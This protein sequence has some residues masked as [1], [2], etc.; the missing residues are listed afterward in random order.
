VTSPRVPRPP[1]VGWAH[2]VGQGREKVTVEEVRTR[3][4][5][6]Y[7]RWWDPK[8]ANWTTRSLRRTLA[9]ER[10]RPL[11]GRARKDA[12]TWAIR[13]AEA[14]YNANLAGLPVGTET[15]GTREA[16]T[17][18]A[19][20]TLGAT[21]ARITDPETGI[22][23][24]ATNH[25]RQVVAA[26]RHAVSVLGGDTRWEDLGHA[27][28]R[29]FWRARFDAVRQR[30]R[31][32]DRTRTYDGFRGP[33]KEMNLLVGLRTKLV[34]EG[35]IGAAPAPGVVPLKRAWRADMTA[36]F[37]AL[38]GRGEVPDPQRPRYT[39]AEMLALFVALDAPETDP[40][41]ALAVILAAGQRHGQ[42]VRARRSWL[43]LP[44]YTE[45]ASSYGTLT[46]RGRGKKAGAVVELTAGERRALDRALAADGYLGVLEAAYQAG[47][48]ADYP[49]FP[50][51]KLT[52]WAPSRRASERKPLHAPLA[53]AEAAP[54]HENTMRGW[55]HAL[56]ARA[57]VP[58]VAGRGFYGMR[59]HDLDAI[60]ELGVS[61]TALQEAGGWKTS[62][63]PLDIY[64]LKDN[65]RAR[66]EA[67]DARR[68]VRGE[69]G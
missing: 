66:L 1:R 21:E 43:A 46:I 51:G 10:G 19:P 57:G 36:D 61:L 29:R 54:L 62:K 39:A 52:T 8:R 12:E 28:W 38:H 34:D 11:T 45:D 17:S 30:P 4:G 40:R 15:A 6:L 68:K 55:L 26:L 60:D 65:Q 7:L 2:V 5:V 18:A 13:Q 67:R 14:Q 69:E 3:A 25:R 44:T 22:Y 53:R 9:D 47:T 16:T 50:E 35:L 31:R 56:E 20:L 37:A 64:R 63:V 33:M 23:A 42:V 58:T 48:I 27:D 41:L 59:R 49:L 32:G 24:A